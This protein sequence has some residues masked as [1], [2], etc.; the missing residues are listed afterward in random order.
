MP[1]SLSHHHV[2]QQHSRNKICPPYFHSTSSH[3]KN[4]PHHLNANSCL[5]LVCKKLLH[6]CSGLS[7]SL[8]LSLYFVIS[9]PICPVSLFCPVF[10][11][12]RRSAFQC[13]VSCGTGIQVRSIECIDPFGGQSNSCIAKKKPT[14]AQ[15]CSTG[16]PCSMAGKATVATWQ[17]T[18]PTP[19]FDTETNDINQLQSKQ[20][21][22]LQR[23]LQRQQHKLLAT[24]KPPSTKSQQCDDSEV[25]GIALHSFV[26]FG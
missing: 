2:T 11:P 7:L 6:F 1:H 13:S 20:Q 8:C 9:P 17:P 3:K 22:Q 25:V 21:Q 23:Q 18:E 5:H 16:I 12:I 14:A 15:S 26:L 19:V 24:A 4:R 10:C